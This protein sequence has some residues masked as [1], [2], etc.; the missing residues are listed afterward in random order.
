M[1]AESVDELKLAFDAWRRSKNF[2][3]EPVPDVLVCF[4]T[5]AYP[6]NL[7]IL[8]GSLDRPLGFARFPNQD[9]VDPL[10]A[11]NGLNRLG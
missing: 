3:R 6:A 5:L 1:V 4:G 11:G 10:P 7:A 2:R 9:L 8:H